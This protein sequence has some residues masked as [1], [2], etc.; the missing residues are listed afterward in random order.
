MASKLFFPEGKSVFAGSVDNM[1]LSICNTTQTAIFYFPG[2]GTVDNFL[3]E[4]GLYPS[5]TYLYFRSQPNDLIHAEFQDDLLQ[6]NAVDAVCGEPGSNIS[7]ATTTANQRIMCIN[8]SC[9][10]IEG[11]TCL[12]CQ[13]NSEFENCLLTDKELE[14]YLSPDGPNFKHT[15]TEPEDLI[16]LSLA[17]LRQR[18]VT[19]FSR[20]RDEGVN[21]DSHV[22]V[23]LTCSETETSSAMGTSNMEQTSATEVEIEE[24]NLAANP[25]EI[26]PDPVP[27]R[28]LTVH[29]SC[30]KQD[31]I[32]HFKDPH[33]MKCELIF[34]VINERGEPEKGVGVGVLREVFT[35]F[36]GEFATS[37]TI[38][39]RERVPFV[40]H[41]HFVEEWEAIGRILVKGYVTLSYYPAFLSKAFIC[42][43]LFGNQ[44]PDG[45]LLDSF[46]KYLS[47]EEEELVE[48]VLE[49]HCL[50][51]DR[52]EFD[53][54]LER[55]NC[56]TLVKSENLL[57]VLLEIAKQELIQKPHLMIA[58]WQSIMHQLKCYP[59]FQSVAAV[60]AYYDSLL[61]SNKKVLGMLVSN[62]N[63]DA[64]RDAFKFLQKFIR[65]LDMSKL[66][67]FLCFTTAMDVI[68]GNKLEVTFIKSEG[69]SSRPIAHTC[70]PVLELPSSYANY[71]ELRE[72]FTNI[73]SRDG[74]EM[75]IM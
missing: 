67:R 53:D 41:D 74:W 36:W 61:P 32:N 66:I 3:K 30:I 15:H 39:E 13:Q 11:Q 34:N 46:K 38:G 21:R 8:C 51:D 16:P 18:R 44:V 7:S 69:F 1:E 23:D 57:Q 52:E 48:S 20:Q 35:L 43:C 47:S 12:I 55:F 4:N 14:Q 56:R 26:V 40:R 64:E 24:E 59:Q 58:S 37:M 71:V 65:G 28:E 42:Y 9:T 27:L 2:E 75:D 19:T 10:Y 31:L 70:G 22:F 63:T 62:P 68:V 54:F 60:K 33:I 45:L 72:E 6:Q 17:E 50:P 49:N 25:S 29:R 73:L 5:T